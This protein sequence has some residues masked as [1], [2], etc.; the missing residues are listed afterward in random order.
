VVK[1]SI[2]LGVARIRA[3]ETSHGMRSDRVSGS[4]RHWTASHHGEVLLIVDC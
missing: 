1:L 2:S 4:T 3:R